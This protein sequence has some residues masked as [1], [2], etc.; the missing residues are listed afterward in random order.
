LKCT[1]SGSSLACTGSG[2]TTAPIPDGSISVTDATSFSS[3]VK[4]AYGSS[5]PNSDPSEDTSAADKDEWIGNVAGEIA[6][7]IFDYGNDLS[8]LK[9]IAVSILAKGTQPDTKY[10]GLG[11]NAW[12][13]MD[14]SVQSVSQQN[15]F[16]YHRRLVA[17]RVD[18]RNYNN[19]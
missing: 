17:V 8:N 5:A 2:T 15:T 18:F 16:A 6:T 19:P 9:A 3:I 1:G 4:A 14:G 13:L 12:S 10:V 11:A 7:G